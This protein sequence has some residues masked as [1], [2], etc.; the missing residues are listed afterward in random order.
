MFTCRKISRSD[1]DSTAINALSNE[2]CKLAMSHCEVAPLDDGDT[3]AGASSATFAFD[4]PD[5]GDC[6]A[7]KTSV[8][9]FLGAGSVALAV[10]ELTGC[11]NHRILFK[12]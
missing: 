6:V 10:D 12:S 7:R 4:E 9:L 1:S 8:A 5:G 11:K 2:D 3:V